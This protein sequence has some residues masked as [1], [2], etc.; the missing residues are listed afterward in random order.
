MAAVSADI[1]TATVEQVAA[2]VTRGQCLLFLG[3][4]VHGPPPDGS[5]YVYGEDLRPP[6]GG[7]LSEL[8]AEK[9][10]LASKYPGENTR[11][12]QRT[13]LFF[14]TLRSRRQLV[15][16]IENAVQVGK[17]PSPVLRGLA[18]LGFPLIITT[19][20]D[21]LLEKAMADA[22]KDPRVTV[23]TPDSTRPTDQYLDEPSADR[24]FL[25]KIH[26]DIGHPESI[27]ITDEDYIQF[28][29]RMTDQALYYPVPDTFTYQFQ[30]WTT[31]FVGYSLVDY[32]LRLLFKTLRWRFDKAN[33]PDAYSVD[34]K[35]DPLILE[36]FQNQ[37]K[38]LKFIVQDVWMFVPALY[39]AVLGKEMPDY[40]D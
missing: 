28:V 7:T 21:Q 36:V 30:R 18:E 34:C 2:A 26:G 1:D 10:D 38:Y 39:Q 19:N 9:C 17:K 27:V 16:E 15:E 8:L 5:K 12:L 24:P 13:S 4:G 35:P 6:L 33:I 37:E 29:L 32:N 23:Y 3:A 11:N 14:E 31:L 40:G 20:F 22:G 25:F